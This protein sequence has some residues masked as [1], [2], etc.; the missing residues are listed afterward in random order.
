MAK[1]PPDKARQALADGFGD[2]WSGSLRA[3]RT[4]D[5]MT[6]R[7][8][9]N[10][11][12]GS[13][14]IGSLLP[15]ER[16][17]AANFG[18]NRHTVRS[19]LA[20]LEAEGLI[21]VR[22]G[23]GARVLDYRLH[24]NLDLMVYLSQTLRDIEAIFEL[25][26]SILV[27]VIGLACQHAPAES[28]DALASLAREQEAERVRNVFVERDLEFTREAIRAVDNLP[29]ELMHNTIVTYLRAHPEVAA[30]AFR[31]LDAIRPLYGQIVSLIRDGDS[32][33]ARRA[34][35]E[36]LVELDRDFI[37]RMEKHLD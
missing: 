23:D 19:A 8:R 32:E 11:L 13:I 1:S 2:E 28:L 36:R 20:R 18:V 9:E 31:N 21:R 26:R 7:L 4:V 24:G 22:Q 15:A 33:T 14:E 35:H 6:E 29:M 10:I 3:P 34:T 30:T 25:R 27:E 37:G 5:L 16:V 17:L 12:S